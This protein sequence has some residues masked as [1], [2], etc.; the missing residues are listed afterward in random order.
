[1]LRDRYL[2]AMG[3]PEIIRFYWSFRSPYAWFAVHRIESALEGLGVALEWIPVFPPKDPT[4]MPNN[5]TTLPQ[6]ARYM[7][8]DSQRFADK[9]G[10]VFHIPEKMDTNWP[11]PHAAF[12]YAQAQGRGPEFAKEG[13]AARFSRGEDLAS[14]SVLA[15]IAKTIGLGADELISA[16]DDP[17]V[18]ERLGDGF[19]SAFDDGNF[20]VP[21]FVYRDQ[22]FFGNDRVDWLVEAVEQAGA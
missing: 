19:K 4:Q 9:Y 16:S 10:L 5:P 22:M 3:D 14:N 12:L 8:E 18:R 6:K 11:R 20:G 15:G 21:T 2:R 1:M 13:F 7:W 17:N